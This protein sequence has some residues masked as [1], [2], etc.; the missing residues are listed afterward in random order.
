MRRLIIYREE[1]IKHPATGKILGSDANIVGHAKVTQ[2]MPDMSKAEILNSK[3]TET[4]NSLDK[5]ITE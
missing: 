3:T 2:V 5:V 4:I 1:P